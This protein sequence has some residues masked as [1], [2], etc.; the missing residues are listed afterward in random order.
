M[1][2]KGT[3]YIVVLVAQ[4][5]FAANWLWLLMDTRLSPKFSLRMQKTRA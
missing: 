4:R 3:D 2:V 1:Q 5:A